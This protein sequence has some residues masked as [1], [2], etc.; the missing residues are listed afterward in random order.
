MDLFAGLFVG[1][2]GLLALLLGYRLFLLLLPLWGFVVGFAVGAKLVDLVFNEGFLGS[3][4]AIGVG[5]AV[6]ILFAGL[7]YLFWS[8]GVVIALAGAGFVVGYAILPALGLDLELIAILLG[9]AAAAV[10]AVAAVLFR[11]PRLLIVFVT[12]VW[13]AGAVM[14]GAFVILQKM[15]TEQLGNGGLDQVLR[16]SPIWIAVWLAIAAA[17]VI[18]QLRQADDFVLSPPTPLDEVPNPPDPRL[19]GTY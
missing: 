6:A 7:A 9:L 8:I 5:V 18:F 15:S 11:L 10:V 4:L 17:G 1:G 16:D 2:I 13:G 14:A 3:I 12:A 19:P